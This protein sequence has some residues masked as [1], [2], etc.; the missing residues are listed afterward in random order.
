MSEFQHL[1]VEVGDIRIIKQLIRLYIH[2]TFVIHQ[3]KPKIMIGILI[4]DPSADPLP[5]LPWTL[6]PQPEPLFPLLLI[7]WARISDQKPNDQ[8][9]YKLAKEPTYILRDTV[10][11]SA[12]AQLENQL[13]HYLSLHDGVWDKA[14]S[15]VP[16][17]D[18]DGSIEPGFSLSASYFDGPL[19]IG[20]RWMEY[21][22]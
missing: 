19:V 7:D 17:P 18:C 10:G 22:K 12:L 1:Y 4:W 3:D 9:W 21:H 8:T 16:K 15:S 14:W 2:E 13:G 6:R 5:R 20:R 11:Y